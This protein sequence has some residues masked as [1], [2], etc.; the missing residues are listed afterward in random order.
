[1]MAEGACARNSKTPLPDRKFESK[2]QS[3]LFHNVRIVR[4]KRVV[5]EACIERWS[6]NGGDERGV[7]KVRGSRGIRTQNPSNA[8]TMPIR[9]LKTTGT[10]PANQTLLY[11]TN[12]NKSFTNLPTRAQHDTGRCQDS[13]LLYDAEARKRHEQ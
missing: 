3:S 1:M 6:E 10:S 11:R 2:G 9:L 5:K 4:K 8:Q 12:A 7:E 13:S